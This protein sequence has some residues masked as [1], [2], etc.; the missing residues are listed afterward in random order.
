MYI[1]KQYILNTFNLQANKKGM[2]MRIPSK[3]WLLNLPIAHRGLWGDDI[4]EN[5]IAAYKKAAEQGFPIEIDLYLSKDG[6]LYSFHD[7]S[8]ERMT[9]AKGFIYEKTSAEINELKLLGSTDAIPTFDQ[10]L[11]IA[12]GKVPLLIEIKNQPDK[13]V[14]DLIVERL[15]NYKGEFAIQSFNPVYLMRVKKLAP[16]FLRGILVT[17]DDK[18]LTGV[19]PFTKII[20]K[21]MFLN[22]FAK[23]DFISARYDFLPLP[24]KKVK[25]LPVIA[26]TVTDKKT[27][28]E[29]KPRCDNYIFEHFIPEK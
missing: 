16:K 11:E 21:S 25:N 23:P 8:T 1:Q 22:K 6:V 18:D 3:H 27:A 7:A 13:R 15:K 17:L 4:R 26:W 19:N 14:T 9:G 24:N 5:S 28:T 12:E 20:L 29:L 2:N 10:V